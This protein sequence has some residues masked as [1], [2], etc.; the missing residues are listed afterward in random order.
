MTYPKYVMRA[1]L[2]L[3][4]SQTLPVA[5]ATELQLQETGPRTTPPYKTPLP[6]QLPMSRSTS[7]KNDVKTAWLAKPTSRYKHGV[8]GDELEAA[9]L[10]VITRSGK[11]L[12]VELEE[13]RV[14]EDLE[15]RIIDM[16]GDK[17]DEIIVVES[18]ENYGASLSVFGIKDGLLQRI[19][20]SE[21]LGRPY[22]WLNPAGV[23]DF[24][25]DGSLDI[26]L[27]ATPH[28]GGILRLYHYNKT[29]LSLFAEKHD[30]STHTIGS[31]ELALAAVVKGTPDKFLLPNQN[32]TSLQ[33]IEWNNG[34]WRKIST[35]DLPSK[36]SSSLTPLSETSWQ[37]ETS[38][39]KHYK[40]SV[41]D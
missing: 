36:I 34:K 37:F 27:V 4:V 26:A 11:T 40:I 12:S 6:Q 13:Q 5:H 30:V 29:G 17:K 22:R 25:A 39:G 14:F 41:M 33:L 19:T 15:P 28:I 24:D 20:A 35:I 9:Q 1:A 21:F 7:G 23:G 31:T 3:V 2:I 38:T 32:H 18:D 8:L 16:D 10:R